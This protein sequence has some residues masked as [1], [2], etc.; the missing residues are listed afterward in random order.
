MKKKL[1]EN[2]TPKRIAILLSSSGRNKGDLAILRSQLISLGQKAKEGLTVYIF[3]KDV[4]Q[5]REYLKD[6]TGKL[7][8]KILK[9]RINYMGFRTILTVLMRCDKVIIGG[10]GLFDSGR[11]F[12]KFRLSSISFNHLWG[13]FLLAACLKLLGKEY[14]LHAVGCSQRLNSRFALY[15][16]RFVVNNASAVS[17][18]DQLTERTFFECTGKKDIVLGSDPAFLLEPKLSDRAKEIVQSW[19]KGK[20]ILLSLHEYI[21]IKKQIPESAKLLKKFLNQ[22]AQF[23]KQNDYSILTYTNYTNQKYASKI[24]NLSGRSAKPALEGENHLLPEEIIYLFSKVDFVIATQM[25][26]GIFAYRAGVPFISLIYTDKVEELNR[27]LG[28]QNYLHIPQMTDSQKVANALTNAASGKN[29]A[30]QASVKAS[31]EKLA[32]LLNEFV[33]S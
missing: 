15:M 8:I 16:T 32:N 5:I 33:W 26:G 28:N 6:I 4:I 29:I 23:A 2:L 21:F 20:K 14:I 12:F 13:L 9:S 19:P 7:K 3:T 1:P 10:G 30:Q 11:I 27:Q 25:H 17:V 24:A 18:R 22:V 31:S